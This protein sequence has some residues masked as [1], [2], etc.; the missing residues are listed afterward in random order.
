M[1]AKLAKSAVF[2]LGCG[3]RFVDNSKTPPELQS[4]I[5]LSPLVK[6]PYNRYNRHETH[7][8]LNTE[9]SIICPQ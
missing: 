3:N 1:R 4:L 7:V 6:N 9:S 8:R 2:G 5:Y